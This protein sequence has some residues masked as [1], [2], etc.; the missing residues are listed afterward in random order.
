MSRDSHEVVP[1]PDCLEG[2]G[3]DVSAGRSVGV[4]LSPRPGE[5]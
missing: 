1:M 3:I 2:N 5:F 4:S